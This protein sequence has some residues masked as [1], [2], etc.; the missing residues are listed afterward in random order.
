MV[1]TVAETISWLYPQ[2]IEKQQEIE[3][4]FA[5]E[6]TKFAKTLERGSKEVVKVL[7]KVD[8]KYIGIFWI[9]YIG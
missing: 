2:L 5:E 9:S 1:G 3:T 7:E 6:E 8:L 4:V